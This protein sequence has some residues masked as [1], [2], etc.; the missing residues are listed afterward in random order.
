MDAF[1]HEPPP[2]EEFMEDENE[3]EW[4]EEEEEEKKEK[5]EK[6]RRFEEEQR[7]PDLSLPIVDKSGRDYRFILKKKFMQN[8]QDKY[9]LLDSNLIKILYELLTE[10]DG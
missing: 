10:L 3:D 2:L 7:A 5:E 6:A 1:F 8:W 9:E 4:L